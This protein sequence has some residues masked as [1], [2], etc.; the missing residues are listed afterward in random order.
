[1]SKSKKRVR[2]CR[3]CYAYIA[4]DSR[5]CEFCGYKYKSS[6]R[7]I[8]DKIKKAFNIEKVYSVQKAATSSS[9][10]TFFSPREIDTMLDQKNYQILMYLVLD[11]VAYLDETSLIELGRTLLS[12]DEN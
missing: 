6:G 12:I 9:G 2:S 11:D 4:F 3:Q 7:Y 5:K 10:I 1:M 8:F